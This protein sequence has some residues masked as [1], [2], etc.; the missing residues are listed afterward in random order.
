MLK[1]SRLSIGALLL[2]ASTT[3]AQISYD[4]V[5]N[6]QLNSKGGVEVPSQLKRAFLIDAARLSLR[7]QEEWSN[8]SVELPKMQVQ[9]Y[10]N[11]LL[12]IYQQ[13]DLARRIS[14][15]NI[16]TTS[17]LSVDYL[18]MIYDRDATWAKPLKEGVNATDN[19][20]LN[21]LIEKY[22]LIIDSYQEVDNQRSR[23]VIRSVEPINMA[24]IANQLYEIK[25]VKKINLNSR[26]TSI[27]DIKVQPSTDGWQVVYL[28][29]FKEGNTIQQHSWIYKVYKNGTVEFLAEAGAPIPS[30]ISCF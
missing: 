30:S 27:S 24:A 25:E 8:Q 26:E 4:Y 16:H 15:C 1:V 18:E 28:I 20:V 14:N 12:N 10:H 19:S 17:N 5:P 21:K 13:D 3:I 22:D 6:L 2:Y 29:K 11:L 9:L 23:L 7:T